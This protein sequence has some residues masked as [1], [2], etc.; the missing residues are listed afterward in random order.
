VALTGLRTPRLR[1]PG[2]GQ[3]TGLLAQRGQRVALLL[4]ACKKL[5]LPKCG[6]P[7]IVPAIGS[8]AGSRMTGIHIDTSFV[9]SRLNLASLARC[10]RQFGN[11]PDLPP[12]TWI[13]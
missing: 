4:G 3:R 2:A 10:V 9:F 12:G 8:H 13:D 5:T 7:W 1:E 11:R 6:D